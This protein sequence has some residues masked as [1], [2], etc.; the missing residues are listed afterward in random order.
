[1]VS[2]EI[3][4]EVAC[5]ATVE[6]SRLGGKCGTQRVDRARRTR[7]PRDAEAEPGVNG[8]R[9]RHRDRPNVLGDGARILLVDLKRSNLHVDERG[10]NVGVSHQP[11]ERRQADAGTHHIGGKGVTEPMWVGELHAGGPTMVAEQG[12]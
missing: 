3:G 6:T 10:L 1:M 8:S 4:Q 9:W 11:H 5:R 12:S 2:A 7:R